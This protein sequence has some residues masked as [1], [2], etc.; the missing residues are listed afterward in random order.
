M[1][2]DQA[3]DQILGSFEQ[4][5]PD[6][7]HYYGQLA[8]SSPDE[9][10]FLTGPD[11]DILTNEEHEYLLFLGIVLLELVKGTAF[12]LDNANEAEENLWGQLNS[13]KSWSV[14]KEA[15]VVADDD[16]WGIFLIDALA[17]D[18]DT[19]FLTSQ[20]ATVIWVKLNAM[21]SGFTADD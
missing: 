4:S 2:T 10:A 15:E 14:E 11:L 17:E 20:G 12:I 13:T 1:I 5:P 8:L 7:Q 21:K 9:A 16:T 6:L 19:S 18:E 3:I